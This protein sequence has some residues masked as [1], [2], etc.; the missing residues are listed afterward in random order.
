MAKK[1]FFNKPPIF[2][3]YSELFAAFSS[4]IKAE[5]N[6]GYAIAWGRMEPLPATVEKALKSPSE[7]GDGVAKK[8]MD[9]CVRET[10]PYR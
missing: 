2:G 9:F 1:L 6:G 3:A 8:F 5:H 7:G 10:S 4:D